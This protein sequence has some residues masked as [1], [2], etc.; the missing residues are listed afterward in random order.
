MRLLPRLSAA[1]L[2]IALALSHA[3]SADV[4]DNW[5]YK[6]V[7]RPVVPESVNAKHQTRNAIDRLLLAKLAEKQLSYAPEADRRTLIRRV[8]FD[9]IGLP[10]S[11]REIA[12]FLADRSSDA[13]ERLVD[14]LLASP[15][16]GEKWA[17]P[18]ARPRSLRGFRRL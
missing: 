8:S 2:L 9:L 17:R 4:P 15:H 13:Y 16:Y 6:P 3:T 11:P 12:E 1:A 10:P 18:L 5:A 7:V 14:R